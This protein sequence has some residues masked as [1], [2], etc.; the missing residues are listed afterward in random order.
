MHTDG[1]PSGLTALEEGVIQQSLVQQSGAAY[2]VLDDDTVLGMGD[3]AAGGG[4]ERRHG[5]GHG[6]ERRR[7]AQRLQHARGGSNNAGS[8]STVSAGGMEGEGQNK[9][10]EYGREYGRGAGRG[11]GRGAASAPFVDWRI[12]AAF[13]AASVAFILW[14]TLVPRA[15]CTTDMTFT[16]GDVARRRFVAANGVVADF[17]LAATGFGRAMRA[18]AGRDASA[19][20]PQLSVLVPERWA[21]LAAGARAAL[22]PCVGN[23]S[24]VAAFVAAWRADAAYGGDGP[25]FPTQCP[26]AY[27]CLEDQW[28]QFAA[29]KV[30]VLQ[31]E[32]TRGLVVVGAH[33]YNVT[34]AGAYGAS[35]LAER[36]AGAIAQAQRN[37]S[38]SLDAALAPDAAA[39]AACLDVLAL[40]GSTRA[41]RSRLA[42]AN[43]NVVAWV[44]FGAIFAAH[45]ARMAAAEVYAAD[46]GPACLVAVGAGERDAADAVAR[47]V[48][49]VARSA[50]ADARTVVWVVCD[51]GAAAVAARLQLVPPPRADAKFYGASGAARVFSGHYESGRH[52]VAYV[53]AAKDAPR[54]AADS[55]VMVAGQFRGDSTSDS[56]AMVAGQ[57][58]GD[59]IAADPPVS[60]AAPA[61]SPPP[62]IF[63]AEE[64]DAHL[65][66]L[67]HP[68]RSLQLCL[69]VSAGTV[70]DPQALPQFAARMAASPDVAALSGSLYAV[71]RPASVR[72]VAQRADFYLQHFV[73]PLCASLAAAPAPCPLDQ[74]FAVFRADALRAAAQRI[75]RPSRLPPNECLL[76]AHV[77]AATRARWAFEPNARAEVPAPARCDAATRQWFRTRVRVLADVLRAVPRARLAPWLWAATRLAVLLL[78]PAAVCMLYVEAVLAVF[79]SAPAV[80]VCELAAGF[81]AASLLVLLA[82]RRPATALHWLVYIAVAVP[83]YHVWIPTTA[84]LSM[85][86]TWEE[87]PLPLPPPL[88]PSVEDEPKDAA[89]LLRA[90]AHALV[91]RLLRDAPRPVDPDSPAFYALCE[92]ALSAL[93]ATHP[94]ANAA[95]LAHAVN[96]AADDHLSSSDVHARRPASAVMEEDESDND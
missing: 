12:A 28:A 61:S 91:R 70:L 41:A 77:L 54:G 33:A 69:I 59:S 67:G 83:Y 42:C 29:A 20:F 49:S 21:E 84:L 88:P 51:A 90:D 46:D 73:A 76:T 5:H 27:A 94:A 47:T 65:A 82:A 8:A 78:T 40:R 25:Q 81:V 2:S 80:V 23:A 7:R 56:P 30:G 50:Y 45:V 63:L 35:P 31:V 43:T 32:D 74:L 22:A 1:R 75:D 44:T 85:N 18:Y 93:I 64:I 15:T 11:D 19:A 58:R 39:F 13:A 96:H 34:L 62:T 95:D 37:G 60:A 3:V 10:R 9:A 14:G 86:R 17:G 26:G 71:G 38:A 72:A 79:G 36:L 52:R 4:E 87:P 89:A 16:V 53:L 57:P 68:L 24:A 48:Q 6:H 66:A 92:R 55:L